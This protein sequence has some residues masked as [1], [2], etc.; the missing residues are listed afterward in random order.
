[1]KRTLALA[2]P[3]VALVAALASGCGD[4]YATPAKAAAKSPACP[5]A[6]RAGWQALANRIGAPVY[7][8]SWMPS[9]LDAKRDGPWNT[10]DSVEKDGSYLVGFAW[11]E[12]A[13]EVHVNFRGYPGKT[14]IPTCTDTTVGSGK[15]HRTKVPCFS[16]PR[17]TRRLGPRKVTMF[18]VNRDADQW[19]VLYAWRSGGSLYAVSEHIAPPLTYSRVVKNLDRMTRGLV[20]IRPST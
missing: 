13:E 18:T 11:Q 14:A 19:H 10:V 7:C 16:D 15:V 8:P 6:W 9:P 17:G 2:V 20:E 1:V 3:L 12:R 4:D 5:A